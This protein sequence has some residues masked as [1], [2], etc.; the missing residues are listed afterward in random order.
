[1]SKKKQFF[2]YLR[3][4]T[5]KQQQEH[6]IEN[7]KMSV[8]N[9]LL[10]HPEI[11]IKEWYMDDGI[12]AFKDRPQFEKMMNSLQGCDGV[13]VA[14]LSRIG[15]SAKQLI[16]IVEKF[17]N[18]SKDFICV[19]DMIDT[20][21]PQGKFFFHI[22][23]AMNEYEAAIIKERMQEG[24][25]RARLNGVKYGR[26]RKDF[27]QKQLNRMKSSYIDGTGMDSLAKIFEC[28]KSTIRNR[29]IEMDVEIRKGKGVKN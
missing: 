6:T 2:A 11:E 13:I 10:L 16:E 12:S 14:K 7:Q 28:S 15:R 23:A 3:V 17:N 8:D 21:T 22:L 26:K 27:T 20:T 9:Y 24:H 29:L 18:E 4:S 1:M 5:K 19:K 25:Y